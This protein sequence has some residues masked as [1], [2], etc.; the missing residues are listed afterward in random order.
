MD[1][2]EGIRRAIDY[3][4]AHLTEEID[5]AAVA[6]C[7]VDAVAPDG[8]CRRSIPARTWAVFSCTGPMPGA[9]Q[10]LWHHICVE[11]FPSS[12][13]APTCEMDIEVYFPGDRTAPDYR[14]EIWIPVKRKDA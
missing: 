4:E 13:Y 8:L 3:I 7:A 6:R 1:W 10:Q 11:F 2:A 14:C 12:A 5:P 9:I